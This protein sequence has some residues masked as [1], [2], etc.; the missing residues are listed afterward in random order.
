MAQEASPLLWS[1]AT[2]PSL[3]EDEA[4]AVPEHDEDLED[5][6]RHEEEAHELVLQHVLEKVQ[7]VEKGEQLDEFD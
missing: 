1:A 5:E 6:R 7:L 4:V 3:H 2:G